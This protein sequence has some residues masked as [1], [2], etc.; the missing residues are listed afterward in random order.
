MNN[1]FLYKSHGS[2][3]GVLHISR[4]ALQI[5]DALSGKPIS[6]VFPDK[7][8]YTLE[9][10]QYQ[11]KRVSVYGTVYTTDEEIKFVVIESIE[12]IKEN[13]LP[14]PKE[15]IGILD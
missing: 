8:R 4:L 14:S 6:C 11:D 15:I 9:I 13:N 12:E 2:V 10:E 5:I 1:N 7:S 3:E